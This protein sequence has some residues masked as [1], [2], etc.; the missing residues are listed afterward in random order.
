MPTLSL[1]PTTVPGDYCDWPTG[2]LYQRLDRKEAARCH[3]CGPGP[4]VATYFRRV[5]P[6]GRKGRRLV[7]EQHV[8]APLTH[9]GVPGLFHGPGGFVYTPAADRDDRCHCCGSGDLPLFGR[10]E[11]I[12]DDGDPTVICFDCLAGALPA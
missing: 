12:G 5:G 7:C 11:L 1:V 3:Q 2:H 4:W 9:T 8:R 6:D 10:W